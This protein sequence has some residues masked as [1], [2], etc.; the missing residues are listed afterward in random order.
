MI[1]VQETPTEDGCMLTIEDAEEV[2][3]TGQSVPD[4]ADT[5]G[6]I[7]KHKE[8]ILTG[9]SVPD[10]E[11]TVGNLNE[12]K[13]KINST[14]E[15]NS[16]QNEYGVVMV[17]DQEVITEEHNITFINEVHSYTKLTSEE[18]DEPFLHSE[19]LTPPPPE[20]VNCCQDEPMDLHI[21]KTTPVKQ[22]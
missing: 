8:V 9:Q 4:E 17:E 7:N 20:S 14:A 21:N 2:I 19:I 3:S 5:V 18:L 1:Y 10:E 22:D 11:D 16:L 15:P 13:E 12:D 6:N